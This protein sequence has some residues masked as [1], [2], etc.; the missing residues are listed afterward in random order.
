MIF[1]LKYLLI[2]LCTY[3]NYEY[4]PLFLIDTSSQKSECT[5][6]YICTYI[7]GS[8]ISSQKLREIVFNF[9]D[10]LD[11]FFHNWCNII[12]KHLYI[13]T[14]RKCTGVDVLVLVNSYI[15]QPTWFFSLAFF[16]KNV[17]QNWS[18]LNRP[19]YIPPLYN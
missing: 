6:Y 3:T 18:L 8:Q 5:F 14:Q 2:G 1:F 9:Y 19:S 11:C 4:L 12:A 10:L 13:L 15:V 16:F 17:T 7:G